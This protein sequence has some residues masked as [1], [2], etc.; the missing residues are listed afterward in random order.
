MFCVSHFMEKALNSMKGFDYQ[1]L[2]IVYV[3]QLKVVSCFHVLSC[4]GSHFIF[5]VND[6][7]RASCVLCNS[8]DRLNSLHARLWVSGESLH[9]DKQG[10][11]LCRQKSSTCH[12]SSWVF[13]P[14]YLTVANVLCWWFFVANHVSPLSCQHCL[15]WRQTDMGKQHVEDFLSTCVC[16]VK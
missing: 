2:Y 11:K 13:G 15:P 9:D 4:F 12:H 1:G 7:S 16:C 10:K 3:S 6:H 14:K 8:R 5:E